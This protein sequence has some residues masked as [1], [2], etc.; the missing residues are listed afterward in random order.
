M[1][2]FTPH[3]S[4]LWSIPRSASSVFQD[5]LISITGQLFTIQPELT[6]EL[7]VL[8][9]R[10]P[11][12]YR[13]SL[14]AWVQ[15]SLPASRCYWPRLENTTSLHEHMRVEDIS[16]YI[17]Q[18]RIHVE[19]RTTYMVDSWSDRRINSLDKATQSPPSQ[20]EWDTRKPTTPH[21]EIP[22]GTTQQ[23]HYIYLKVSTNIQ[24]IKFDSRG[25]LQL[26]KWTYLSHFN[27]PQASPLKICT[28]KNP[29]LT[30]SL[31]PQASTHP[32][33][34]QI[35][36]FSTF[37]TKWGNLRITV[38]TTRFFPPTW[39]AVVSGDAR[40]SPHAACR[41]SRMAR[42][43]VNV[44]CGRRLWYME[45]SWGFGDGVEV[46]EDVKED[47]RDVQVRT[48]RWNQRRKEMPL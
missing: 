40:T 34:P 46:G 19:Q 11:V 13:T 18:Q 9:K 29:Y 42:D 22:A 10:S 17:R 8:A 30:I 4:V 35:P 12:P 48:N 32:T 37:A 36:P 43:C 45:R 31:T 44:R 15:L 2:A 26:R 27:H 21:S 16:H 41:T 47:V 23:K 14:A 38:Q 3:C 6:V 20:P 7:L 1:A 5:L 39:I 24:D 28:T 33:N 25:P